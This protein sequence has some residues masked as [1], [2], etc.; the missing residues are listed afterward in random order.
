M[1]TETKKIWH[2]HGS[3]DETKMFYLFHLLNVVKETHTLHLLSD[4][5]G[6]QEWGSREQA[7]GNSSQGVR[8]SNF[9]VRMLLIDLA[10]TYLLVD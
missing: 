3:D 6:V 9:K 7:K 5:D 2:E 8:F 10:I 1:F 4:L